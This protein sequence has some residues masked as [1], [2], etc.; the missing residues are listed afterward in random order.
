M[1]EERPLV[2]RR[3]WLTMRAMGK[4]IGWQLATEA[5]ATT[6]IEHP[7]WDMDEVKTFEEWM[8]DDAADG[9]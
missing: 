8:D 9:S 7:E 6:A 2:S 5:V 3:M 1:N 4:G